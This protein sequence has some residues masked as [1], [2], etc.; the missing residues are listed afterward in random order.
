[1]LGQLRYFPLLC[2]SQFGLSGLD[3]PFRRTMKFYDVFDPNCDNNVFVFFYGFEP[4]L[5]AGCHVPTSAEKRTIETNSF[6]RWLCG[7]LE[8]CT[9]DKWSLYLCNFKPGPAAVLCGPLTPLPRNP[10]WKSTVS[11]LSEP[12]SLHSC[13]W[14]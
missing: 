5:M 8:V 10:S 13:R 3:A 14:D 7:F 11:S 9:D 4:M 2:L 1:M 6:C 12:A